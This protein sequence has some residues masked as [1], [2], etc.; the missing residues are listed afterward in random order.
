MRCRLRVT[1]LLMLGLAYGAHAGVPAQAQALELAQSAPQSASKTPSEAEKLLATT[2]L[3]FLGLDDNIEKV[4]E[5]WRNNLMQGL[6]TQVTN[7]GVVLPPTVY[8]RIEKILDDNFVKTLPQMREAAINSFANQFSEAELSQLAAFYQSDVG[9]LIV[10]RLP[11]ANLA[12]A[13]ALQTVIAQ[14][15]QTVQPEIQSIIEAQ[16]KGRRIVSPTGNVSQPAAQPPV[17]QPSPAL[18]KP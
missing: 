14:V 3:Q 2:I 5:A 8:T 6:R 4:R 9:K 13:Q 11:G 16:L 17:A 18:P 15:G 10:Q 7:S 12:S 1:L